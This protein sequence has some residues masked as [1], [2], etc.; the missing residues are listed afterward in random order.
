MGMSEKWMVLD[1]FEQAM[2]EFPL[3]QYPRFRIEHAQILDEADIPRFKKLGVI[4]SMQGIH[5]T[6]DL[7][8]VPARLGEDRI[9]WMR[10]ATPAARM[11]WDRSKSENWRILRYCQKIL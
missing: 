8:W 6:S 2:G 4:A 11:S 5:A 1:A 3:G 9:L 10:P 7:P